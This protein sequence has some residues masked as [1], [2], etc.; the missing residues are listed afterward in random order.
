M[1]VGAIATAI[2][3]GSVV[4]R[5]VSQS[6]R[7]PKTVRVLRRQGAYEG[8]QYGAG[9]GAFVA[10]VDHYFSQEKIVGLPQKSRQRQYNRFGQAR[11]QIFKSTRSRRKYQKCYDRQGRE[12][13]SR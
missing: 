13:T 6:N 11:N 9:L 3:I 5:V 12:R 2:R 10:N 7:F 8:A 1:V 4:Y